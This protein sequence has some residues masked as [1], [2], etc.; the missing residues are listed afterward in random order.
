M[1]SRSSSSGDSPSGVYVQSWA[2]ELPNPGTSASPETSD[3]SL[4]AFVD[5][6]PPVELADVYDVPNTFGPNARYLGFDS[7]HASVAAPSTS[8]HLVS[9][10]PRSYLTHA[11]SLQFSRWKPSISK[12][13]SYQDL[14]QDDDD[15]EYEIQPWLPE[16]RRSI[17]IILRDNNQSHLAGICDFWI[18]FMNR[19]SFDPARVIDVPQSIHRRYSSSDSIRHGMLSTAALVQGCY[20]PKTPPAL[21]F[22]EAQNMASIAEQLTSLDMRRPDVSLEIKLAGLGELMCYHYYAGNFKKYYK[23]LQLS[24][25]I[26]N[27]LV[28]SNVEFHKLRGEETF[29]IRFFA[30]CDILAAVALSRSPLVT[31]ICD[32]EPLL[33]DNIQGR[34][35]DTD[36]VG[37]GWVVG[38]PDAFTMLLVQ[39]INLRQSN[40]PQFEKLVRAVRIEE[41][42]RAWIIRPTRTLNCLLRIER[43]ATQ[44]IWRHTIILYL[45]NVI[46]KASPTN[47]VVQKSVKQIIDLASTIR[48]GR[49]PD[50][51]LPVPYF[52][53]ATFATS[54]KDKHILK[55][56][57]AGTGNEAFV[58]SLVKTLDDLWKESDDTGKRVDWSKK[59]SL[60]F[61]F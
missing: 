20:D 30:W 6:L 8:W 11:D 16:A 42:A 49:N 28:G 26:V 12:P 14:D 18:F 45:Y 31:Y 27:I 34:E 2:A 9:H 10:Q 58:E 15:Q 5:S 51:L 41:I 1:C 22:K 4:D 3:T 53:A 60:T 13:Y 36:D 19:Y 43:M 39:I 17:R 57:V 54:P 21:M 23:Y 37:I 48:P 52:I 40:I 50:C 38:C 25:P 24:A 32:V 35:S 44:E 61:M 29:D 59:Q 46:H 56:R 33:R 55:T 47:E 7:H